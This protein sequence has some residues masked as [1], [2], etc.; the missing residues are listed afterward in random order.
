MLSTTLKIFL[1]VAVR[2]PDHILQIGD[3]RHL[4]TQP[5]LPQLL[6]SRPPALENRSQVSHGQALSCKLGGP[7]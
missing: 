7:R 2:F 6:E 3:I 1:D 4:T 5:G